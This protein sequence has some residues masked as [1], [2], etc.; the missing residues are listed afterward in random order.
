MDQ[1][2]K[3]GEALAWKQAYADQCDTDMA[4]VTQFAFDAHAV[5]NWAD[6]LLEEGY[7]NACPRWPSWTH[8]TADF[9]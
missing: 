9:D 7:Q 5:V 1:V 6:M 4:I 2:K 8:E 3:F